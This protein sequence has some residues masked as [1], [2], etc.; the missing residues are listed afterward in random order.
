MAMDFTLKLQRIEEVIAQYKGIELENPQRKQLEERISGLVKELKEE[1]DAAPVSERPLC[2][3]VVEQVKIMD[4]DF[5]AKHQ[6][7]TLKAIQKFKDEKLPSFESAVAEYKNTYFK[8][9]KR[10]DLETSIPLLGEK[11]NQELIGITGPNM[12]VMSKELL[13]SYSAQSKLSTLQTDFLTKFLQN[14]SEDMGG[15]QFHWSA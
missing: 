6:E 7:F 9:P 14:Q 10:K 2:S 8:D 3:R 12:N 15:S 1:L 5:H 13:E 11:L 4:D